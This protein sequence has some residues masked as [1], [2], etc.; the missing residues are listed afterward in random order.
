MKQNRSLA[1]SA[2]IQEQ[3]KTNILNLQEGVFH[4]QEGV[5]PEEILK[6]KMPEKSRNRVYSPINTLLTMVLTATQE[7]KSL[8]NSVALYYGLHQKIRERIHEEALLKIQEHEKEA[9]ENPKAGR[10]WKKTVTLPRSKAVD[11]SL[12]TAAYSKARTRLPLEMTIELFK[13]SR[14]KGIK[15]PYSYWH[16][17]RVFIGDGT[18]VQMQDAPELRKIYKVLHNGVATEGYPQG[19]LVAVIERGTGQIFE[20][21]LSNRSKTELALFYDLIDKLPKRS[22]VYLDDLSAIPQEK[23]MFE[24]C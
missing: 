15:T 19:L 4:L 14:M 6:M 1:I 20:F 11:I 16:N 2:I 22:I 5:F 24:N 13:A 3:Q 17:R 18:Y 8:K 10:P 12:N 21:E 23:S 9:R 7:D